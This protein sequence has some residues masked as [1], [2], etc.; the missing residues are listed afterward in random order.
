MSHVDGILLVM[1]ALLGYFVTLQ[2]AYF[3]LLALGVVGNRRRSAAL[4]ATD[5]ERVRRSE[6]TVPLSVVIPAFNEAGS[7]LDTIRSALASD[8]PEFEVILVDDGSTD[9]TIERLDRVWHLVPRARPPRGR[10]PTAPVRQVYRSRIEPRLWVVE[11][12]N[13]GK[14]DAANAGVNVAHYRYVVLT[15]ADGVY[16][17]DGL[18]R[19]VQPINADPGGI[20]GLGATI[21]VLNGCELVEGRVLAERVPDSWIARF[22]LLEYSSA[23]VAN[24]VGWSELNAVPVLSG[25]V[26]CWRKDAI[27]EL[28]GFA[29]DTT[30]EDLETTIRLHRRFR[31]AGRP[32]RIVYI[33]DTVLW[34]EVPHTWRGLYRQRK[35]WQRALFETVWLNRDMI[36]DPRYGTVGVLLMPYLL[37]YEALGP[38]VEL[39]A[40]LITAV[41]LVLGL[42]DAS[43]L[44]AFLLTAAGLVT[45]LRL[46]GLVTEL[47]WHEARPLGDVARLGVTALLEYWVYR[48]FLAVARLH[49][50][51]EFARGHRGHERAHR[52]QRPET[53]GQAT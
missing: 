30:H 6:L 22:Q 16:A 47:V 19:M 36:F 10:L 49:A 52:Q 15:D 29:R 38:F 14:A 46:A 26:S 45:A 11:K 37:L 27:E 4:R 53:G 41:V 34:T 42:V 23:F 31:E 5:A 44:I 33:P 43:I 28:G 9:D 8:F 24:R 2:V 12:E 1:G 39:A 35:R 40:Y 50:F 13:G 20:V 21:G 17:P 51:V 3:A 48:P 25:G 32:Y 7:V 18:A